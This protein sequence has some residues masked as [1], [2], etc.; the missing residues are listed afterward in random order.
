V[1]GGGGT[2][3][4]VPNALVKSVI[5]LPSYRKKPAISTG[6]YRY[7]HRCE[8]EIHYLPPCHLESFS[9]N[10]KTAAEL[11]LYQVSCREE[12]VFASLIEAL[13]SC[14]NSLSSKPYVKFT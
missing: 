9:A 4:A 8:R 2:F 10:F 5:H 6:V 13:N 14:H 1:I 12:I 3:Y 7:Q 11:Q